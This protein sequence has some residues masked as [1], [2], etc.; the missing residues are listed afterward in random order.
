MVGTDDWSLLD[1]HTFL[2]LIAPPSQDRAAILQ[3]LAPDQEVVVT[4]DIWDAWEAALTLPGAPPLPPALRQV[5]LDTLTSPLV[6]PEALQAQINLLAQWVHSA[7]PLDT[8]IAA[9]KEDLDLDGLN[10]WYAAFLPLPTMHD[11]L[12]PISHT[13]KGLISNV[14]AST[15]THLLIAHAI[16]KHS[17]IANFPGGPTTL[18][19]AKQRRHFVTCKSRTKSRRKHPN[20]RPNRSN[21][22]NNLQP[23]S[24]QASTPEARHR[25]RRKRDGA[26]VILR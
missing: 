21:S 2:Y 9:T 19:P 11:S 16:Y 15:L 12:S 25:P 22:P 20:L 1:V 4:T 26:K 18:L 10:P 3:L 14:I 13:I 17:T 8:L 6:T 5:S 23:S 7:A 24:P